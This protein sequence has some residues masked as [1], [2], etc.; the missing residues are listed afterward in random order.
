[1]E[2]GCEVGSVEWFEDWLRNEVLRVS[3]SV[4]G[5]GVSATMFLLLLL[6]S[7]A[8]EDDGAMARTEQS[9]ECSR[10]W[11]EGRGAPVIKRGVGNE[12]GKMTSLLRS[13][14]A[15]LL[16]TVGPSKIIKRSSPRIAFNSFTCIYT[17]RGLDSYSG[18][19]KQRIPL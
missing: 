2:E 1:M 13:R 19:L 17:V 14:Y 6:S 10:R 12:E 18:V 7:K 8:E 16:V 11:Y 15:P 5:H 3:R 9:Y 4:G